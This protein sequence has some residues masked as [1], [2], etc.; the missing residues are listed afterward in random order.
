MA[1]PRFSGDDS[2]KRGGRGRTASLE[3][4]K[5]GRGK[6]MNGVSAMERARVR[7]R[8]TDGGRLCLLERVDERLFKGGF[9][10]QGRKSFAREERRWG[11]ATRSG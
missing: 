11:G 7:E 1:V 5:W 10:V 8:E 9:R 4:E 6:E 3:R 2:A